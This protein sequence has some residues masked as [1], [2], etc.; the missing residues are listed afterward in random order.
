MLTH[1][2][3]AVITGVQLTACTVQ[4]KDIQIELSAATRE[5]VTR[6]ARPAAAAWADY[7]PPPTLD[8]SDARL[9]AVRQLPAC[10]SVTLADARVRRRRRVRATR[11]SAATR[12][13]SPPPPRATASSPSSAVPARRAW[14]TVQ[15]RRTLLRWRSSAWAR[16]L[17]SH[18]ARLMCTYS[19]GVIMLGM[20]G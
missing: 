3:P 4:I 5:P 2:A 7:A 12:T 14:Y 20:E 1:S 13:R 19:R 15:T 8:I 9:Q 18:Q 10:L 16:R 17:S 6:P 11:H